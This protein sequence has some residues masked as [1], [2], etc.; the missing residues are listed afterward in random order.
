VFIRFK[1]VKIDGGALLFFP[2]SHCQ[3]ERLGILP[4]RIIVD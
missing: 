3:V 1:S 2:D 4:A